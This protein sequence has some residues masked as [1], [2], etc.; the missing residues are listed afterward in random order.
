MEDV[1]LKSMNGF[2]SVFEFKSCH[3]PRVKKA[4]RYRRAL[5]SKRICSS[6]GVYESRVKKLKRFLTE[7]GYE[8]EFVD[9]QISGVYG[10]DNCNLKDSEE[11]NNHAKVDRMILV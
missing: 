6:K 9:S 3:P 1:L 7:K 4:I 11:G 5:R 10:L 8:R 2:T